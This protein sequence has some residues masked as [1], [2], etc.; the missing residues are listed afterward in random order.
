MADNTWNIKEIRS[1]LSSMD[2]QIVINT[3]QQVKNSGSPVLIPELIDLL[4][5]TRGNEVRNHIVSILN[6]LKYQ[7]SASELVKAIRQEDQREM[8]SLLVAACWKNGLDYSE[9][10]DDFIHIFLEYD[11]TTA[12]EAL[13]VI[14]NSIRNLELGPTQSRIDKLK[15]YMDQ[16][17]ADKRML[18]LELIHILN[19]KMPN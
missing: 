16:T 7:S 11:Y 9:Y 12:L 5:K 8:V 2:S 3:L 1:G 10:I 13:T 6:N 17:G 19:H 18:M 15:S 4:R 14:E